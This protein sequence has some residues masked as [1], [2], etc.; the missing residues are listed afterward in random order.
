MRQLDIERKI[1]DGA[2]RLAALPEPSKALVK[3]RRQR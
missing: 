2:D 3:K 1:L